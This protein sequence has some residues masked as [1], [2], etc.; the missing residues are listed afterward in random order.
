ML[1]VN[2]PHNPTGAV[3]AAADLQQLAA[4]LR[5]TSIVLLSDEVYEHMVFD[6]AIHQSVSRHAELAERSFVIGSFGKTYH[7][8][9]WKIG[10]CVAPPALTAAAARPRRSL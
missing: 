2:S 8:T 6:G 9:G 7:C 4:L 3:L 10:Y 1:I 5:D